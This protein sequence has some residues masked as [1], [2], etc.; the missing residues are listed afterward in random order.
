MLYADEHFNISTSIFS[1]LFFSSQFFSSRLTF[2]L[3]VL[4]CVFSLV[5]LGMFEKSRK[6]VEL[7]D[8]KE[9]SS[10][11]CIH[12]INQLLCDDT[13]TKCKQ[14]F[15]YLIIIIDV[16]LLGIHIAGSKDSA[17]YI[18]NSRRNERKKNSTSAAIILW[19]RMFSF[20]IMWDCFFFSLNSRFKIVFVRNFPSVS[21]S[22][23]SQS[24]HRRP[25]PTSWIV[26][27]LV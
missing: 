17:Q 19:I 9:D 14:N 16:L 18:W 3:C 5:T 7:N 11:W 22:S 13:A 4:L 27:F 20:V 24:I 2:T 26:W 1:V 21:S 6:S 10:F 15:A 12:L 25:W 8:V 23:S